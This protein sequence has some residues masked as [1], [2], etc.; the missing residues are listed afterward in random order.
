MPPASVAFITPSWVSATLITLRP[1]LAA[2]EPPVP[3]SL[4]VGIGVIPSG[5]DA[6]PPR[7]IA[8]SP[9]HQRFETGL[10]GNGADV[11]EAL[12]GILRLE[13]DA[14]LDAETLVGG[15]VILCRHR[16]HAAPVG[17]GD[18]EA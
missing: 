11:V 4:N 8:S 15:V 17:G 14:G 18:A 1:R 3:R 12:A 7:I 16:E 13:V 5:A 10:G 6:E 2:S 9:E